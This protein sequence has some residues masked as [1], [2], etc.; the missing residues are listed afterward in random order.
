M[1]SVRPPLILRIFDRKYI[2]CSIPTDEKVIY[3]TFDD[4]PIPDVTPE[5]VRILEER[6]CKATFFCVGDNVKKYPEVFTLITGA[7]H[8]VGN[9]TFHHLNGWRT[10]PA[11]YVEDV[12]RCAEYVSTSLFRPPYGR[13]TPSQYFLL[14]KKYRFILWSVL[15][16]DYHPGVSQE[17]CLSNV[18]NNTTQGSIVVF[19]DSLKAS[20]NLFYSLPRFLDSFLNKGYR[21]EALKGFTLPSP[22]Q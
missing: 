15:S 7:G 1:F 8:A 21:F 16:G 13:F 20:E 6:N 2:S 3:L 22:S 14:H 5:V 19:H 4:G 10:P 17:Q 9:H 12:D 11:Q 18:L